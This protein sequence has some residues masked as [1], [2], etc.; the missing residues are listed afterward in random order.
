MRPSGALELHRDKVREIIARYPVSNPR[1][2]G[3][4]ARG[5]DT[6]TSDLDLLVERNGTLTFIDLAKL[7]IELE[8]LLGVKV[9]VRT[10]GEFGPAAT[11]RIG[12]YRI[13]L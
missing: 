8:R 11:A 6:D 4:V 13:A 3:S 5:E 12:A 7:E 10:P 1:V 9:D 2:F